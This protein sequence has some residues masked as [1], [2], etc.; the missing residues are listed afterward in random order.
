MLYEMLAGEPPLTGPTPQATA[1][2]RLTNTATSLPV[3]RETV[4]GGLDRVVSRALAKSPADRYAKAEAL[5]AAL[6]APAVWEEARPRRKVGRRALDAVIALVLLAAGV[7]LVQMFAGGGPAV[8]LSESRIA[9]L[10]FVPAASDDTALERLGHAVAAQISANLQGIGDLKTVSYQTIRANEDAAGGSLEGAA[11]WARNETGAGRVAHGSLVRTGDRVSFEVNLL[12]SEDLGAVAQASYTATPED[13]RIL[14]DSI[15]WRILGQLWSAGEAPVEYYDHLVGHPFGAVR[16]FLI[17]EDFYTNGWEQEKA[18]RAYGRAFAADTTFWAA[19]V[20]Y[21]YILEEYGSPET[22]SVDPRLREAYKQRI[23]EVPTPYRELVEARRLEIERRLEESLETFEE[24]LATHPRFW[25]AVIDYADNLLFYGFL[26]GYSAADA[27]QAHLDCVNLKPG[28]LLCW[29]KLHLL[30]AGR[31]AAAFRRAYEYLGANLEPIAAVPHGGGEP[32]YDEELREFDRLFLAYE[33]FDPPASLLDSVARGRDWFAQQSNSSYMTWHG[34]TPQ[35]FHDLH[36]RRQEL[37]IDTEM[38]ARR[39]YW[40]A[41][42]WAMRGA[43]DSALVAV[44]RYTR[45]ST[46]DAAPLNAFKLAAVG[47][48]LGAAPASSSDRYL[49]RATAFADG[50][51]NPSQQVMLHSMRGIVGA[52]RLD[53]TA[54]REAQRQLDAIAGV[55]ARTGQ[56]VLTAYALQ[57]RGEVQEAADSLYAATWD[58]VTNWGAMN[59]LTASRWLLAAGDSVRAIRLLSGCQRSIR[60]ASW[61]QDLLLAGHCYLELA[62]IEEARGRDRVARDYYWQFLKRY[63]S[64]VEAL[65]PTVEEAREAYVR[66]GGDPERLPPLMLNRE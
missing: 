1:A 29:I 6:A 4:P 41:Y 44:D 16:D 39:L 28:L 47:E 25:P 60:V 51:D 46:D 3:L 11:Q 53:N 54:L 49:R 42:A 56:R 30:S 27:I 57:L 15:S 13:P 23:E 24:I 35:I 5:A 66:V 48:W 33:Q 62:R 50:L 58:S 7:F 8:E 19:S 65:R 45:E 10:P 26:F 20:M 40:D 43:W 9:V 64:P 59:Q 34:G 61:E 63:D 18:V 36:R 22:L 52:S 17:A 21:D 14:A 2:L 38:P 31:D 32:W 37:E 55:K 12:S